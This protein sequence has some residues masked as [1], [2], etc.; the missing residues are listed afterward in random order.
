MDRVEERLA[1]E[2][3]AAGALLGHRAAAA[4]DDR[5][6][7]SAARSRAGRRRSSAPSRSI[8]DDGRAFAGQAERQRQQGRDAPQ[9]ARR[10]TCRAC[11]RRRGSASPRARRASRSIPA[12]T[13]GTSR[14]PTCG[15][16]AAEL[17]AAAA[18]RSSSTS[19]G[20]RGRTCSRW[21]DEIRPDQCHARAGPPGEVT[22][23][24]G[25][26]ARR[27]PAQMRAIR[28]AP[29]GRPAS[30][31]A[32][33]SI[34]I[35]PRCEWAAAVGGDRIE[36]YTEPFARAFH[37]GRGRESFDA[38]PAVAT[39]AH[40]LGL[41]VNAGHDLDLANLD[42]LPRPAASRRSVD[43]PRAHQ[44]CA[45]RRA[46]SSRAGLHC[47][48]RGVAASF[49]LKPEA[50]GRCATCVASGFAG[51]LSL[52]QRCWSPPPVA[53][54]S[55][56]QR[57]T[58]RTDDGV[59]LAAT[60][61]EPSSRAGPAVILVHMLTRTRRE[62]D[63]MAQRLASDGIGALALDLRGHGESGAGPSAPDRVDYSAMVQDLRAARRFL[64][65]R[66]DVQQARVGVARRLARG[67]PRRAGGLVRPLHR[68]PR[69]AVALPGLSRAAHRGGGA[70]GHPA[71]AA[72]RQ[73]TTTRMRR[74]R[75][76][77]C[78]KQAAD[79]ASC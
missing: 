35:R 46:R 66:S 9:L 12:P 22:S 65:Q 14:S 32:S 54:A 4:R 49:R 13:P 62:W 15:E 8:S 31:S 78:R 37:A 60:W 3:P 76:A 73:Q 51:R 79:R 38:L 34:R 36:L 1:G 29:E 23:Q 39:L 26:T 11:S 77:S 58:F 21:S 74:G 19:R 56:A 41:G 25:W 68:Q 28:P 53:A 33:S 17:R 18:A 63:A 71:D 59:T 52:A 72:G 42:A 16:I 69:A 5:G 30:A 43:R 50:T 57:V 48:A 55:A 10:R 24:A 47:G 67:Q 61:Y 45:L 20:I 6:Q 40:E 2:R 75:P 44:P 64:A 27:T 70:E 7:G